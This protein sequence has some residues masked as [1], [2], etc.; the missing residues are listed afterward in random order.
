[1]DVEI[2]RS[3]CIDIASGVIVA[4]IIAFC[5]FLFRT[6]IR[7]WLVGSDLL[8]A[9]NLPDIEIENRQ[10]ST[11][12]KYNGEVV[13]LITNAGPINLSK[14]RLFKCHTEN[15][16]RSTS[17][18]MWPLPFVKQ[19]SSVRVQ[20][21]ETVQIAIDSWYFNEDEWYPDYRL[22]IEATTRDGILFRATAIRTQNE[23]FF[24]DLIRRVNK[25]LPNRIF[26]IIGDVQILQVASKY[27]LD[28]AVG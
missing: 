25:S 12:L 26:K 27:N 1:M 19:Y 24:V 14:V 28:L 16:G 3:L 21:G 8:A 11:D 22:F 6:R 20:H 10:F 4:I 18:I 23:G 7:R 9:G 2:T 5:G 15:A 17:L 13:L